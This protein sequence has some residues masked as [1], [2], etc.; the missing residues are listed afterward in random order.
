MGGATQ[1][2]DR[3]PVCAARTSTRRARAGRR[4][5]RLPAGRRRQRAGHPRPP[6]PHRPVD[7][8]G[9]RRGLRSVPAATPRRPPMSPPCAMPTSRRCPRGSRW[10]PADRRPWPRPPRAPPPCSRRHSPLPASSAG[11]STWP[12]CGSPTANGCDAPTPPPKPESSS[13][14]RSTPSNASAPDRGRPAPAA[15]YAPPATAWPPAVG[16]DTTSLTPQEREIALLAATGLTNKQIGQRLHLSHRTVG[17]HLY[18]AFPKLGITSRAAPPRR[19][20]PNPNATS[21][22]KHH[23]Q[24]AG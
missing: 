16:L 2:P 23:R 17:A 8:D 1:G 3:P 20:M 9:S 12:G 19:P 24:P 10:W 6:C 22:A 5:G 7:R 11:R 4:R 15:S 21:L 14:Q 13:P 18:R